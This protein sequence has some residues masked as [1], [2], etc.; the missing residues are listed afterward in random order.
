LV[1]SFTVEQGE[2]SFTERAIGAAELANLRTL[3]RLVDPA[4]FPR[5]QVR[6]PHGGRWFMD[7]MEARQAGDGTAWFKMT[8]PVVEGAGPLAALAGPADWAHGIGRP[9]NNVV[10]DPN[11]NLSVHLLR[12]PRNGWIG[13]SA[14]AQWRAEQ[15]TGVGSAILLDAEGE[16]GTVTMSVMLTPFPSKTPMWWRKRPGARLPERGKPDLMP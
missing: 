16:I 3:A 14:R 10:A 12:P 8:T 13:I 4:T 5:R 11:S 2:A 6:A 7:A 9:L 1:A 15:G